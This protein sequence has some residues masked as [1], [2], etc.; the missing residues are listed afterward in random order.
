MIVVGKPMYF[1]SD[2]PEATWY[3]RSVA[4]NDDHRDRRKAATASRFGK[5]F[6]ETR[7]RFP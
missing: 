1:T 7:S 3:I 2:A 5:H 4:A 6:V